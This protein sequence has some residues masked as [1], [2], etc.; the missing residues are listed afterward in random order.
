[1]G[2]AVRIEVEPTRT[3]LM[4]QAVGLGQQMARSTQ[5]FGL[6]YMRQ[7]VGLKAQLTQGVQ[8][9]PDRRFEEFCYTP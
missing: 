7:A 3:D 8:M 6:G 4:K 5:A 2:D 1:M 9:L